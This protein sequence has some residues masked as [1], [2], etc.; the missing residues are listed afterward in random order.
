MRPGQACVWQNTLEP[1]EGQWWLCSSETDPNGVELCW[2]RHQKPIPIKT[3]GFDAWVWFGLRCKWRKN[4]IRGTPTPKWEACEPTPIA[5]DSKTTLRM[6]IAMGLEPVGAMGQ[7]C[8]Q[9]ES[10][11]SLQSSLDLDCFGFA[12]GV[13][14]LV[15]TALWRKWKTVRDELESAH[16]QFGD[17]YEY[18]AWLCERL[19]G[20]GWTTQHSRLWVRKLMP[21][22]QGWQF[23]KRTHE[24]PWLFWMMQ[25]I[26]SDMVWWR[27]CPKWDIERSPAQ[28]HVDTGVWKL[29]AEDTDEPAR[30]PAAQAG[31]EETPTEDEEEHGSTEGMSNLMDAL[32]D[33]L[34]NDQNVALAVE[35]LNDAAQ[36]QRALMTVLGASSGRNP[37]GMTIDMINAIRSVFQRL[38]RT[39]RNR[40]RDDGAQAYRR[41]I[42]D[43]HGVMQRWWNIWNMKRLEI[44]F[45]EKSS[46]NLSREQD[47][48]PSLAQTFED[49]RKQF[50]TVLIARMTRTK[51]DVTVLQMS[52][53]LSHF[54]C[55]WH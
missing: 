2:H 6:S 34:R 10:Q 53:H 45:S 47:K 9:E 51:R 23:M 42:D 20:F 26:A 11:T 52:F 28:S 37:R 22:L 13:M 3:S 55:H 27:V 46:G 31:E 24:M 7:Q 39:C 50:P 30:D 12:F 38:F 44:N 21:M 40:G 18:A 25:Q 17:H 19:D 5:T 29:R 1:G 15:F 4:W 43:L 36:I 48:G 33:A 32:R 35:L 16:I 8:G 49:E 54:S 41:Y 14:I